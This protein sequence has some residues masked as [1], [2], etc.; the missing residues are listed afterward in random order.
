M[1]TVTTYQGAYSGGIGTTAPSYYTALSIATSTTCFSAGATS[2]GRCAPAVSVAITC[3]NKWSSCPL[4]YVIS[5]GTSLC[6]TPASPPSPP[7]APKPKPSPPPSPKP[8][9]PPSPKPLPPPSPV[10][11]PAAAT[12]AQCT[13]VYAP[14][15]ALKGG[16]YK[17][18]YL[19]SASQCCLL[20]A[21]DSKCFAW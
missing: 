18:V 12:S 21:Q 10:A 9:P 20:C 8:S 2:L 16:D 13:G 3:W 11:D 4:M 17:A 6:A 19:A 5:K 14:D 1:F 7:P 15:T